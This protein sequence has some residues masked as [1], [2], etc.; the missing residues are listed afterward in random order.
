[1]LV[2]SIF[3]ISRLKSYKGI[4]ENPFMEAVKWLCQIPLTIIE[5]IEHYLPDTW[6]YFNSILDDIFKCA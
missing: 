4:T 1:M 6:N 5:A 2:L 3:W